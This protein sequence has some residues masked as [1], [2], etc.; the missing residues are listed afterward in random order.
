MT[1]LDHGPLILGG[2]AFGWTSDRDESFAVLDAFLAAGGTSIDT[3]DVYSAW[4]DGHVGGE[5]ETILG[6]WMASRGVR[7]RVVVATKVF[8]HP[9]RPGLAAANVRAAVDDSLRRLQTDRIDLYYAHRDDPEVPQEEVAAVFDELV[10]AGK[11][12]EVGASNFEPARLRSL[13]EVAESAGLARPTTSQDRYNLVSREIEGE[14]LPT[15]DE[16]GIVEAPYVSLASGFLTGK[17]RP[18]VEV[19]SQRAGMAGRYLEDPANVALLDVLDDVAAAHGTTVAA[20]SLA[21]LRQQPLVAAPLASARTPQQ[22]SELL[23]SADVELTDDELAR[24]AA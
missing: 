18:G 8:S 12:R 13:V 4:V 9:E 15:L 23:A 17:Y 19:D 1:A 16:L 22:L 6:E 11:V 7:D 5:S 10:R 3:A 21:W 24:L 2:N 14:L 20:V